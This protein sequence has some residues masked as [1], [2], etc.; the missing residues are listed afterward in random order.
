M[1]LEGEIIYEAKFEVIGV[2]PAD[3]VRLKEEVWFIKL[4]SEKVQRVDEH[5]ANNRSY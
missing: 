5:L 2:V 4:D 1:T 3:V